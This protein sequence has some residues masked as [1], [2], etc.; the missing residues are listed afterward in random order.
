MIKIN[1]FLPSSEFI[2]N[3][4]YDQITKKDSDVVTNE[5][6]RVIKSG[7]LLYSTHFSGVCK[8]GYLGPS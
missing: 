3:Y 8:K 7:G 1:K 2:L 6:Q 5:R 4:F